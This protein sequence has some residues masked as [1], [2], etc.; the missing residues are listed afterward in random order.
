M[1]P[2]TFAWGIVAGIA[3]VKSGL[4]VPQ[5]LAMTL[6]VYSGVSQLSAL[7]LLAAGASMGSIFLVTVLVSLRFVLYTLGLVREYRHLP[8]LRRIL[9]GYMTTDT[10]VAVYFD[11]REQGP[12]IAQRF[13]YLSG[14]FWPVWLVWQAASIIGIFLAALLP[15]GDAL[16]YFG[17]LAMLGIVVP[18]VSGRPALACALTSIVVTL[19]TWS[20]PYK[21]GILLAVVAGVAAAMLT[22]TQRAEPPRAVDSPADGAPAEGGSS[23]P[24]NRMVR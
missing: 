24:A 8:P 1:L 17:V 11:R 10:T 6:L 16:A 3:M 21:L 4:T 14:A 9:M 18:R 2:G 20:W 5:A 7:P 15:V 13:A 12:P 19:V 22:D 23:T